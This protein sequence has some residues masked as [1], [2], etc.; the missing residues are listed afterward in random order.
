MAL[1]PRRL[2]ARWPK[3]VPLQSEPPWAIV[4]SGDGAAAK[5]VALQTLPLVKRSVRER[6]VQYNFGRACE[7]LGERDTAIA[8]YRQALYRGAEGL[9]VD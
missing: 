9:L 4:R 5:Q 1:M 8:A 2:V 3:E 6:S 7:L